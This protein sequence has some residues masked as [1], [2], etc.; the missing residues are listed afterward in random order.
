MTSPGEAIAGTMGVARNALSL[1]SES[2]LRLY[3][4]LAQCIASNEK[5]ALV[6]EQLSGLTAQGKVMAI[7]QVL[8]TYQK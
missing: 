6:D 2:E 7:D 8:K 3:R 4:A 1:L 5:Y